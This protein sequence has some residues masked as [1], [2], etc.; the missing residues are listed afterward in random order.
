MGHAV[1]YIIPVEFLRSHLTSPDKSD[2]WCQRQCQ[3]K[4]PNAMICWVGRNLPS[5]NVNI[6][7]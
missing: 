6:Y 2:L 1:C 7:P 3:V 5:S 4:L